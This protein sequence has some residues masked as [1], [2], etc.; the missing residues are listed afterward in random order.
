MGNYTHICK[1]EVLP[2]HNDIQLQGRASS[3]A[4]RDYSHPSS[5]E[6]NLLTGERLDKLGKLDKSSL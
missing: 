5:P 1:W 3:E 4:M 6:E 2:L